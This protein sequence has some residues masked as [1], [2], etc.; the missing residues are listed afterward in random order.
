MLP[1]ADELKVMIRQALHDAAVNYDKVGVK[2]W[3]AK[4]AESEVKKLKD[5]TTNIR[6]DFKSVA[7]ILALPLYDLVVPIQCRDQEAALR[8]QRVPVLCSDFTWL[9]SDFMVCLFHIMNCVSYDPTSRMSWVRLRVP[10]GHMALTQIVLNLL[11][12]EKQYWRYLPVGNTDLTRVIV[13]AGT[14]L[15]QVLDEYAGGTFSA[16]EFNARTSGALYKTLYT[17]AVS[18]EGCALASYIKLMEDLHAQGAEML[19]GHV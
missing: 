4:N 5:I 12:G 16:Q 17:R 3:L 7:R 1:T 14:I 2:D 9:D 19:G 11:W 18:L 6:N 10:F 13:F 8:R 15:H